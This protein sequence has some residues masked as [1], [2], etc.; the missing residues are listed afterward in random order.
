[1]SSVDDQDSG[2][3]S[4]I[5]NTASRIAQLFGVALAAGVAIFASGY[6]IGLS[7]AALLSVIG[8]F[9]L[10]GFWSTTFSAPK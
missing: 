3:A 10:F 2:L 5:N 6:I 8:A 9:C 1:M 7:I 4:G